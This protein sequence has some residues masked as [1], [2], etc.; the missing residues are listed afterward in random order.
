[1]RTI[2]ALLGVFVTI[3]LLTGCFEKPQTQE[4]LKDYPVDTMEGLV[5]PAEGASVDGQVSADGQGS[6]RI[7]VKKPRTIKLY[8][9][10]D[11]DA[12][13]CRLI[14]EASVRT[15]DVVGKVYLEMMCVFKGKGEYFSRGLQDAADGSTDWRPMRTVFFLKRGE[16][17]DN[18]LL[19]LV[20]NGTG[21]VWID[22][23]KLVKT[24]L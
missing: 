8:E 16:N 9:T 22:D 13:T 3:G 4:V 2:T 19:N 1:M 11:L 17:P 7:L 21:T 24:H 12:E 14:Y 6:L 10:G 15:R 20:V 5:A 23:V 18:V